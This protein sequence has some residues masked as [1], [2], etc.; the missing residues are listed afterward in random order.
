MSIKLNLGCF[1]KKLPEFINIDIR[2]DVNPDVVD[3]AFTLETFE[4]N[5]VDLIY[6]CHML[7]HLDYKETKKALARWHKV[8]K[9]NGILRISVPNLEILFAH[10]F[11]HKNLDTL[12]TM[13]YGSQRHNFDYHKNGWDFIK[14]EKELIQVGFKSVQ[15]WDWKKVSP[16]YYCDDY[17][18]AYYPHMDKECGKLLSLNVEAIK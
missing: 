7:E 13:L 9:L 5:S 1:N 8:L 11:Y 12:M 15:L 14:L 18:Q 10:Y 6:T 4:E 2:A 16:H 3:N 17:S